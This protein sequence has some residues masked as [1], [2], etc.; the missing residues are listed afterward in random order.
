MF[1]V[2]VGSDTVFDHN[3]S[4]RVPKRLKLDSKK[5]PPMGIDQVEMFQETGNLAKYQSA[6]KSDDACV[7]TS[8]WF[9]HFVDEGVILEICLFFGQRMD[10]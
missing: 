7:D 9:H 2:D 1:F 6:V 3:I 4:P 8:I 10:C 5:P